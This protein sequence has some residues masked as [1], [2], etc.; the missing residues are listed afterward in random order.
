MNE[1]LNTNNLDR[2]DPKKLVVQEGE[3]KGAIADIEL[4][5]VGAHAQ[6]EASKRLEAEKKRMEDNGEEIIGFE[7]PEVTGWNAIKEEVGKRALDTMIDSGVNTNLI[8]DKKDGFINTAVNK[9]TDNRSR[10]ASQNVAE[11][12]KKADDL[13][14]SFNNLNN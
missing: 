6:N 11:N 9:F 5:E 14:K 12:I 8:G 7:S 3:N 13:M 2:I 10:M 4:A 1:T